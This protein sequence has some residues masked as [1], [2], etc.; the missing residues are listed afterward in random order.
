[1]RR[2]IASLPGKVFGQLVI[3]ALLLPSIT[4]ALLSRAEAQVAV[5]PQWAVVEFRNL[6]SPGTAFGKTAAQAVSSELAKTGQYDV[7]PEDTVNRAIGTLGITSPPEGTVNLLRLAQEVRASTVIGGQIVDYRLFS[8]PSGKYAVVQILVAVYDVASGLAV[9]GAQARGQSTVRPAD[10][11]DEAL[12][13]DAITQGASVAVHEVLSRSLPVGTVQ[14]TLTRSAVINKGSRSGFATGQQV[15]VIRGRDQVATA[16]VSDVEPDSATIAIDSSTR[17]I[18]PGDKVRAIFEIPTINPGIGVNGEIR[19]THARSHGSNSGLVTTLLILGVVV[20]LVSGSGSSSNDTVSEVKAEA[21]LFSGTVN[22]ENGIPGVRVTWGATAFAGNIYQQFAWQVYRNGDAPVVD[23]PVEVVPQGGDHQVVDPY[24]STTRTL[25]YY[26]ANLGGTGCPTYGTASATIPSL[27]LG[28]SYQYSVEE[29]Y[30]VDEANTPGGSTGSASTGGAST[31]GLS[32]GGSGLST[33]G[34]GLSTGGT[35]LSTGGTG[36]STG[37]TNSSTTGTTAAT[38]GSTGTTT[39]SGD[40]QCYFRSS[41][42]NA[43]GLAT[44]LNAPSLVSPN[45]TTTVSIPIPFQFG[46]VVTG[47]TTQPPVIEYIVMISD[48]ESFPKN[49]RVTR[50]VRSS[51][52]GTISTANIDLS[53]NFSGKT[54]LYWRVGARAVVDKPGPAPDR[55]TNLRYIFS[56]YQS[57]K[58]TIG[59]NGPPP[60]PGGGI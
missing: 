53:G 31:T 6:K 55:L 43:I 25:T 36:L 29:I 15:V 17:G 20:A 45:V 19:R 54:T 41:R 48:S 18:Q 38:T 9:N 37:S 33:G 60:P 13:N 51:G 2:F 46:S 4:L 14:N 50:T 52:T 57:F 22:T 12:I 27:N 5:L 49:S 24:L 8:G 3:L 39:T 23:T 56:Q 28:Q 7:T 11:P 35:G 40:S 44:P 21:G 42:H 16:H 26:T 10:T 47:V 1:M 32:T 30:E 34:S 59:S 58:R